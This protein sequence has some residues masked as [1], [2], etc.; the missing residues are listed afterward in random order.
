MTYEKPKAEV[1]E[2]NVEGF[3]TASGLAPHDAP[4]GNFQCGTY[5]AGGSC[6]S[7]SWGSGYSCGS[8]T[9]GNCQSVFSP[10]GSTGDGCNAW[11]LTCSKF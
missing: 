6:L 1:F 10:P 2:F 5:A 4:V 7:I 11:K 3:M 9:N 8:F